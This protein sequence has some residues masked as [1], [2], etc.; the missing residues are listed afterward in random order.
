M[1]CEQA[2]LLPLFPT[3]LYLSFYT[4][5]FND[6]DNYVS[7]NNQHVWQ[8]GITILPFC[9]CINRYNS[10]LVMSTHKASAAGTFRHSSELEV[11][12][13]LKVPIA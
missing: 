10:A 9:I 11:P 2:H 5:C 1:I 8:A 4:L 13:A 7:L 6:S 3:G 12:Q